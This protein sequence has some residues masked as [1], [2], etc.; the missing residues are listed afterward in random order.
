MASNVVAS[1]TGMASDAVAADAVGSNAVASD[2]VAAGDTACGGETF[3]AGNET[4][5]MNVKHLNTSDV[6]FDFQDVEVP[7]NLR[8][9]PGKSLGRKNEAD[10]SFDLD[11]M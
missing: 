11:I 10:H 2:A 5:D 3:E 7:K 4:E 6:S 1:D 8:S 9:T